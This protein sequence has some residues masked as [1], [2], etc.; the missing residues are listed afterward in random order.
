MQRKYLV[1]EGFSVLLS[2]LHTVENNGPATQ[3][4]MNK[5]NGIIYYT[6]GSKTKIESGRDIFALC[7]A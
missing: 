5:R 6:Y 1:F 7:P 3:T 4:E 2:E